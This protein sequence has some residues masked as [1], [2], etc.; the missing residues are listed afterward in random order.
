MLLR[1]PFHGRAQAARRLLDMVEECL[2]LF[3]GAWAF[4]SE[5]ADGIA[6]VGH[7]VLRVESVS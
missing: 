6:Q 2:S 1:K 5:L 3:W 7:C 4:V